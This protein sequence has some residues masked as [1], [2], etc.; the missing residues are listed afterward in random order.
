MDGE[1]FGFDE[2]SPEAAKAS[3]E[4]LRESLAVVAER[5]PTEESRRLFAHALSEFW[6]H[7]G[8]ASAHSA[9]RKVLP[10]ADI[11]QFE[12]NA[13]AELHFASQRIG[14][15]KT[16]I[17]AY[18]KTMDLGP[19]ISAEVLKGT[20]A[21]LAKEDSNHAEWIGDFVASLFED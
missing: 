9:V 8:V 14:I 2:K 20:V 1:P 17:K 4:E 3:V 18:H 10:N 6:R 15:A 21:D 19:E 11:E 13:Q 7:F 12:R 16:L 5:L